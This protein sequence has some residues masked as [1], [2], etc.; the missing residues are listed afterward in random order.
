MAA[1]TQNLALS[2]MLFLFKEVLNRPLE[3][4]KFSRANRPQRL[5][6]VLSRSEVNRL[7]ER[8]DGVYGLM[9]GLMYGTGMRFI[10]RNQVGPG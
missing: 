5:P 9:A 10:Q 3:D 4:M 2:S 6:V 1:N 7:L 8:M